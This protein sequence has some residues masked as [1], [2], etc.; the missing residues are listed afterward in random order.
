M[1][2]K[3][4]SDTKQLYLSRFNVTLQFLKHRNRPSIRPHRHMVQRLLVCDSTPKNHSSLRIHLAVVVISQHLAYATNAFDPDINFSLTIVVLHLEILLLVRPVGLWSF[5]VLTYNSDFT[6]HFI[7]CQ[8][9][10]HFL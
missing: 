4:I 2:E 6:I 10:M 5:I 7:L 8:H 1:P 9:I 3:L